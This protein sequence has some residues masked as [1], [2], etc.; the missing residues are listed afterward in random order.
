MNTVTKQIE[1]PVSGRSLFR[2]NIRKRLEVRRQRNALRDLDD[3][4][5]RDIGITREMA[6][7][8]ANRTIWDM[9]EHS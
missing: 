4:S 5:L 7:H 9:P 1:L 3:R 6:R 2:M 8:E